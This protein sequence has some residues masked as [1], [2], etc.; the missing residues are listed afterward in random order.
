MSNPDE[1]KPESD[2][3][4]ERE[5]LDQDATSDEEDSADEAPV[6]ETDSPETPPSQSLGVTGSLADVTP[7]EPP[8][9]E[10]PATEES[11][12]GEAG[13][14]SDEEATEGEESEEAAPLSASELVA[15]VKKTQEEEEES[16]FNWYILKV[17]SNRENSVR[18]ALLKRVK[19]H[20]LEEFFGDIIVPVESVTEFSKNGKKRTVKRKLYPG[21]I[22]VNMEINDD[23]WFLVR[24]TPGIGDFTGAGGK[25]VPMRPQ[26]ID[27]ILHTQRPDD[28]QRP[29]VKFN[30]DAGS[31]VKII[32]GTF[33]NFEGDVESIDETTGRVT[34]VI[35]IFNRST[36]V[37]LEHWQLET[38]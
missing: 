23:T 7:P 13:E 31:R 21:Y 17:Q 11:P 5:L 8:P 36:P 24:E 38:L 30:F 14:A 2:A 33:Q 18:D 28:V 6:V 32:D 37:E 3:V 15:S 20:G 16:G 25:P 29:A 34:V 4:E 10:E 9:A 35:T 22:V 19:I 27:R 26:E 12:E 1:T